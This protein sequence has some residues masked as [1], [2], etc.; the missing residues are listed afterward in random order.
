[1]CMCTPFTPQGQ[2]AMLRVLLSHFPP[3]FFRQFLTD[4]KYADSTEWAIQQAPGPSRFCLPALG[5]QMCIS[6]FS[7]WE[8][9]IY[10]LQPLLRSPL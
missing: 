8:T 5:L 1:M 7:V 2:K 10:H 4:L 9:P 3:Y 6:F